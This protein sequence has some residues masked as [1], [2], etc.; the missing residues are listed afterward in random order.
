MQLYNFF[1][2]IQPNYFHHAKHLLLS[3]KMYKKVDAIYNCIIVQIVFT[4]YLFVF[5]VSL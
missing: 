5:I 1:F 4:F 2:T 3:L